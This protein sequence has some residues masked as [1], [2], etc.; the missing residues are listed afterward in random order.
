MSLRETLAYA[1]D[2]TTSRGD[3]SDLS[4]R[5][6][7]QAGVC[8]PVHH[9]GRFRDAAGAAYE[10]HR[11]VTIKSQDR[12]RATRKISIE[13]FPI[14]T[15]SSHRPS[16]AARAPKTSETN[17]ALSVSGTSRGQSAWVSSAAATTGLSTA[18]T[19]EA[20]HEVL[21]NGRGVAQGSRNASKKSIGHRI[22]G[23][24][25][26]TTSRAHGVQPTY[27]R[28]NLAGRNWPVST[29]ATIPA[30]HRLS[31]D[32]ARGSVHP[33]VCRKREKPHSAR[34]SPRLAYARRRAFRDAGCD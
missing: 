30:N 25:S 5:I 34:N 33:C 15:S 11:N 2:L 27:R 26:T 8:R 13:G 31:C 14:A 10:S 32:A 18:S 1:H 23:R 21:G 6:P 9:Y 20:G 3:G 29:T 24:T 16:A 19:D 22:D 4:G 28:E 7:W 12:S 17:R